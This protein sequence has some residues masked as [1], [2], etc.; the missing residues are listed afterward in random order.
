MQTIKASNKVT[1]AKAS[2]LGKFFWYLSFI[3]I[4]P[5]IMNIVMRNNLFQMRQQIEETAAGID[6]QLKKRVDLLTKLVDE[7]KGSMKFE[8]ETMIQVTALRQQSKGGADNTKFNS[9][10]ENINRVMSGINVQLENYPNLKSSTNVLQLQNAS[11]DCEANIAAARRFY[12]TNV[13]VYNSKLLTYP[14][15]VPASAMKLQSYVYFEATEAD[16]KDVKVDLSI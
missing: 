10:N 7:V 12:N 9:L 16:R 15:N 3:L 13:R 1:Q 6:V 14:S 2:F 8:K 4:V 11:Q 5:L